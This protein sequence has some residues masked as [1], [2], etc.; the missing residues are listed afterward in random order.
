MG[1]RP[2]ITALQGRGPQVRDASLAA[3]PQLGIGVMRAGV[4]IA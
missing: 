3:I 2:E 1:R 4:E